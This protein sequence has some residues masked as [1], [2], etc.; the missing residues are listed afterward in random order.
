MSIQ[1][2]T[3]ALWPIIDMMQRRVISRAITVP[4][5]ACIA[6]DV[7]PDG[8][9][10]RATDQD[11]FARAIVPGRALADFAP[12]AAAVDAK[13]LAAFMKRAGTLITISE[14]PGAVSFASGSSRIRLASIS[15]D[16]LPDYM[17]D[18]AAP[19]GFALEPA[20]FAD[21]LKRLIPF[22]SDDRSRYYINGIGCSFRRGRMTM[23]A[24]DGKRCAVIDRAAPAGTEAAPDIVLPTK[25]A[26]LI[27]AAL[28]KPRGMP[29]IGVAVSDSVAHFRIGDIEITSRTIDATFPDM[30]RA[31]LTAMGPEADSS[32]PFASLEPR[33]A[34]ADVEAVERC[35]YGTIAWARGQYG[36]MATSPDAPH[37]L[38][39]LSL[40]DKPVYSKGFAPEAGQTF[41]YQDDAGIWHEI[42]LATNAG[43]LID[44]GKDVLHVLAAPVPS[45]SVPPRTT[46]SKARSIPAS[47]SGGS[48]AR[49]WEELAA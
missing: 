24:T 34:R 22:V 21:D 42:P 16:A 26:K 48:F 5:F 19:H 17:H 15:D 6:L 11:V 27:K 20:A 33:L 43:G 36:V 40:Q 13:A 8:V 2:E 35:A 31:V 32:L 44:I 29:A 49:P 25:A 28:S 4:I 37:W 3:A 10:L 18:H 46:R 14:A 23:A 41:E 45:A 30:E 9:T 39:V 7:R 12:F 38:A 47:Q 1:I